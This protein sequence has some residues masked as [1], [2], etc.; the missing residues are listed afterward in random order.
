MRSPVAR[1]ATWRAP[2]TGRARPVPPDRRPGSRSGPLR[3]RAR[4]SHTP[5]P[6]RAPAHAV[7]RL[8]VSGRRSL[9]RRAGASRARRPRSPRASDR[10]VAGPLRDQ[11]GHAGFTREPR[12]QCRRV[13]QQLAQRM[14][15]AGHPG[16]RA[17]GAQEAPEPGQGAGQVA[18]AHGERALRVQQ[19]AWQLFPHARTRGWKDGMRRQP[20]RVAVARGF[21][22][23]GRMGIEQRHGATG[24]QD[25]DRARRAHDACADHGDMAPPVGLGRHRGCR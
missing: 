3:Q 25:F 11:M 20:A 18:P 23:A 14:R 22:P 13:P 2:G 10:R 7:R 15:G 5:G 8:P 16:R 17:P 19:I 9:P 4:R 1:A 21:R 24:A 6:I 12:V